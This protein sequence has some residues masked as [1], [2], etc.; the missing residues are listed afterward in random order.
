MKLLAPDPAPGQRDSS[1]GKPSLL[2]TYASSCPW[3]TL[4]LLPSFLFLLPNRRM[5]LLKY[6]PRPQGLWA[7]M[8]LTLWRFS[9]HTQGQYGRSHFAT[10]LQMKPPSR[11][12]QSLESHQKMELLLLL[13]EVSLRPAL[14]NFPSGESTISLS[15]KPLCS[16]SGYLPL[17]AS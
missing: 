12:R 8:E 10:R 14:L 11:G 5:I 2:S 9:V 13:D 1:T 17:N 16:G 6:L 3:Q 15:L 7:Q 4:V